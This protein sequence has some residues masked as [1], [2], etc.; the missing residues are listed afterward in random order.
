M[1]TIEELGKRGVALL[2]HED[3]ENKEELASAAVQYTMLR[4]NFRAL[5][6]K[7]DD[8]EDLCHYKAMDLRRQ[9]SD[10]RWLH[11]F[12]DW[13]FL[14]WCWGYGVYLRNIAVTIFL[15]IVGCGVLYHVGAGPETM[16]GYC[17]TAFDAPSAGESHPSPPP[18]VGGI[19]SGESG[20]E[21]D[22]EFHPLYFSVITFTTIGYGDYAPR[23]WLRVVAAVEGF[24]GLFLMAVF[25]V[26]F[27]RKFLR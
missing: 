3:S 2:R 21:C 9:A 15:V 19:E 4:D 17:A 26:S 16:K 23:G 10:W 18:L 25:T 7:T 13:C 22:T 6:T 24:L 11:R 20:E 5:P 8:E 12:V 14:K 1:L 27:A